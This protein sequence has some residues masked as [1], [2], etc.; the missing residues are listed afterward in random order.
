MDKDDIDALAGDYALGTLTAAERAEAERQRASDPAFGRAVV[1]WERL[2]APLAEAVPHREPSPH[3]WRRIDGAL[4]LRRQSAPARA[5]AAEQAGSLRRRLAAWRIS[6]VAATAAALVLG[7]ILVGRFGLPGLDPVEPERYVAMLLSD[8]GEMGYV[9]TVEP[10]ARR[11]LVRN[12]GVEAPPQKDFELWIMHRG[13]AEPLGVIKRDDSMTMPLPRR[14][15][16]ASLS[17]DAKIVVCVEPQ[18][19]RPPSRE[20]MGPIVYAGNLVRQTP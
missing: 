11:I 1:A 20:G 13:G 19:G 9:V 5:A 6:A 12:M 7:A 17:Q 18:G 10:E 2:L 15:Q 3:L 16:I 4:D 14:L 8:A